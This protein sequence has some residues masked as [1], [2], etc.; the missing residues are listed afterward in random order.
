MWRVTAIGVLPKGATVWRR[1][2]TGLW[3]YTR[4]HA[5]FGKTPPG[6][7]AQEVQ[8]T[9]LKSW[10]YVGSIPTSTTSLVVKSGVHAGITRQRSRVQI[11]SRLLGCNGNGFR[12]YA[13]LIQVHRVGLTAFTALRSQGLRL[14]RSGC[15]RVFTRAQ[16]RDTRRRNSVGRVSVDRCSYL[17]TPAVCLLVHGG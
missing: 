17:R 5:L 10:R 12:P 14:P 3:C 4:M 13:D 16:P 11:P 9:S 15:A 8:S 6:R 1:R 2:R 7:V